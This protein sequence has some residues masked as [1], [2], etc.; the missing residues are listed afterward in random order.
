LRAEFGERVDVHVVDPRSLPT[1]LGLLL[2]DWRAHR[3]G[4]R[5]AVRTL[6]G[7]PVTGVIVNGKLVAKGR[8]PDVDELRPALGASA[9][10]AREAVGGLA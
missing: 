3:V 6:F 1:L 8:W 9:A 5:D 2:R 4:V 7:L 10:P